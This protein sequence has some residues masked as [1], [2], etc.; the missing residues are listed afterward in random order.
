M[1]MDVKVGEDKVSANVTVLPLRA[2][3]GEEKK[4]G[5]M[6]MIEDISDAKRMK[7]TMSRYMDPGIADQL[8]AAGQDVMGGAVSEA[9]VLFS[10]IRWFTT[11]TEELGA[12]GTVTLLNEYFTL[13]VDCLQKEEGMLDKFIGEAVMAAFCV[14]IPH[15]DDEDSGL[16]CAIDMLKVL[17]RWNEERASDG[18][19]PANIGVG[20]NTDAVV[21]GN[22][23]SPKRMNFTP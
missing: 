16:R 9:T 21:S 22:I 12:Q 14:P 13:M 8:M 4:L 19:K 20:L 7:S 11:L 5:S 17:A 6:V 18:K 15:G 3:S 10:D 23:G 2:E 1:D